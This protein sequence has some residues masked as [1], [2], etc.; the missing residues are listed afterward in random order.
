MSLYRIFGLGAGRITTTS[1]HLKTQLLK[2]PAMEEIIANNKRNAQ[3]ISSISA[4]VRIREEIWY[5]T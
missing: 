4:E 2:M 5:I 3:I 1:L